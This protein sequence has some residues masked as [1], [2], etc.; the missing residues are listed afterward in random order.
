MSFRNL[1]MMWI[2]GALLGAGAL[3]GCGGDDEGPTGPQYTYPTEKAFCQALAQAECS[4]EVVKECFGTEDAAANRPK[5]T[6]AREDAC[7][8]NGLAYHPQH[9]D[10]CLNKRKEV[11]ADASLTSNEV[12]EAEEECLAVFSA[13][14]EAGSACTAH[15]DCDTGEGLR[16][17]TR[18]G[19]TGGTC[20]KP[21]S[22][23]G[24]GKCTDA[25]A[26]CTGGTYCSEMAGNYCIEAL[27][28]GEACSETALCASNLNCEVV[29]GA[30]TCVAKAG[31]GDPCMAATD[32]ASG[33]CSVS[34]GGDSGICTDVYRLDLN[35]AS[36]DEFR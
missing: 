11:L 24:G 8:P 16:C 5:C 2:A 22:V 15:T 31:T 25:G 18:P 19:V 28:A 14:G 33:F 35:S 20:E 6:T 29:A 32:C 1:S 4:D 12:K 13:D 30:A 3:A 7:N 27:K 17:I 21:V 36:C 26:V 10:K 23:S 34:S 9:A